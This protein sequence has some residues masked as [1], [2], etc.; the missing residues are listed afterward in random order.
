MKRCSQA[1]DLRPG[2]SCEMRLVQHNLLLLHGTKNGSQ[3]VLGTL[4][5]SRAQSFGG[6]RSFRSW[7]GSIT[8]TAA[9]VRCEKST[10]FR[11][12]VSDNQTSAPPG[13]W[14]TTPPIFFRELCLRVG[15]RYGRGRRL[16]LGRGLL[17]KEAARSEVLGKAQQ[18]SSP[19]GDR[20]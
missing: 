11:S 1:Q 6:S 2:Q 9:C 12:L 3:P 16:L 18:L 8:I 15:A 7:T 5:L 13:C 17:E 10:D 20:T 14:Q 4:W 19:P